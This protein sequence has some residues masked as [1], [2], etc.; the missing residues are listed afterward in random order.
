MKNNI[1]K[2]IGAVLA[3]LVLVIVLSSVMD[4]A[5]LGANLMKH[6][7]D[8]NPAWFIAFV[9]LYRSAFGMLGAYATARLA[10]GK[11]MQHAMIVGF[12]GFA[13]SIVGAIVM[14]DTPP[15]WYPLSL[16]VTALP[17]A[18]LGGR[19]YMSKRITQ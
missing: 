12:I 17:S 11:P 13:L 16:V 2:S 15:H 9:I 14:W 6:P 4:M 19:I 10:P 18:W 3:G 5:L 8:L 1:M 7:F